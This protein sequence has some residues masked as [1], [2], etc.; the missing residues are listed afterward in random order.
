MN[1]NVY[2]VHEKFQ[3]QSIISKTL[4]EELGEANKMLNWIASQG[5]TTIIFE[6]GYYTVS[7]MGNCSCGYNL[8]D[9]LLEL[10]SK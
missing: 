10:A 4:A 1:K 7:S 6:D 3:T 9:V 2:T 5:R 8:R